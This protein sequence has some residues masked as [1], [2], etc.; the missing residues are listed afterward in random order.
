MSRDRTVHFKDIPKTSAL[1][2]DFLYDFP[3]VQNFFSSPYSLEHFKRECLTHSCEL[4]HRLELCQILEA[5]NRSFGAG[6]RTLEQ[7]EKL[8]DPDCW[9]VVS[10]QQ[11]GLFT[12]PAYT[13]YKALTAVKLAAHY[14]CRGIKAV[15]IFWLATEDH[16]L[17]EVDHCDLVDSDSQPRQIRY[18]ASSGDQGR[19]VGTV[20]FSEGIQQTLAQFLESLPKSEFKQ[21]F[22][23][24]LA[25]SY[26]EGKS[27]AS[28][29]AETFSYL[30]SNYG[31]ILIDPLSRPLKALLESAFEKILQDSERFQSL[32][33]TQSARPECVA[34][35]WSCG[36]S[37]ASAC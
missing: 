30:F 5:Q 4:P 10:G 34:C 1:F 35:R 37:L 6:E 31:L 29:F 20:I 22:E 9:A 11:V 2:L 3:K 16:D 12:G 26:S 33:Q 15:P 7:I 19:S 36:R 18:E 24:K 25:N 28:A 17:A 14:A 13:I 27:F 21:E 32:I 23:A 8:K